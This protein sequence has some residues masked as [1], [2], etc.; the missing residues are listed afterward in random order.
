LASP[1]VLFIASSCA[2]GTDNSLPPNLDGAGSGGSPS[3]TG[4]S[5][6]AGTGGTPVTSAGTGGSIGAGTG[7]I[8]GGAGYLNGGAGTGG[9]AAGSGGGGAGGLSGSGGGGTGGGGSGGKAG[10]GGSG[11]K[12]GSGGSGGTPPT[13]CSTNLEPLPVTVS[14]EFAPTGW[15]GD[16]TEISIPAGVN[17]PTRAPGAA[18]TCYVFDYTPAGGAMGWAG[19]VW[20]YPNNNWGALPGKCIAEG[21]TKVVFQARGEAGGEVVGFGAAGASSGDKMLTTAWQTFEINLSGVDYN[22]SGTNGGVTGG[23]SWTMAAPA[24]AARI[25]IDDIRWV[26]D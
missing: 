6:A 5:P 11:G 17:C 24:G 26:D 15:M 18:G 13:D 4:G 3:G 8:F 1:F 12:A 23:F 22:E 25:Y 10:S 20:Q 19:V 9:V 2:I 16:Y 14:A 7:G 21:A